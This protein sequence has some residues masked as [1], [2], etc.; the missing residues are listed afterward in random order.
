MYAE[1]HVTI[2]KGGF[3]HVIQ[4]GQFQADNRHINKRGDKHLRKIGYE[5]MRN[6]KTSHPKQDTVVYDYIVQKELEDKPKKLAKI[7]GLSFK[8]KYTPVRIMRI[9]VNAAVLLSML[10]LMVSGI[11]L[12]S[13]LFLTAYFVAT[14]YRNN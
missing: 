14:V 7:A 6:L 8:A 12:L 9:I 2:R 3:Y 11:I 4:S 10:G 1:N 13:Y 5:V